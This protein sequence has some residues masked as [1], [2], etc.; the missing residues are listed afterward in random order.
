M[1]KQYLH[2]VLAVTYCVHVCVLSA[3]YLAAA[4]GC[5]LRGEDSC[6]PNAAPRV[7]KE[8]GKLAQAGLGNENHNLGY[9][10]WQ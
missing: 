9:C 7:V 6:P 5:W 1:I 3:L 8:R 4:G 10:L 2:M